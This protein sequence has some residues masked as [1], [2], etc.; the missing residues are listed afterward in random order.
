MAKQKKPPA[1]LPTPPPA[2][3]Q[4]VESAAQLEKSLLKRR[5]GMADAFITKGSLLSK[6]QLTGTKNQL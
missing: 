2:E 3:V 4:D 1:P 5:K 6:G